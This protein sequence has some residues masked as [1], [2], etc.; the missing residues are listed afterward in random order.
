[1][2]AEVVMDPSGEMAGFNI[3]QRSARISLASD[4]R[5]QQACT[6]GFFDRNPPPGARAKD[7]KIHFIFRSA[8][9][10]QPTP[11]GPAFWVQ[12]EV[13]LL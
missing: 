11:R 12:L 9:E 4:R 5:L 10:S 6:E 3:N 8:I 7:G 2:E 1:V 13:G